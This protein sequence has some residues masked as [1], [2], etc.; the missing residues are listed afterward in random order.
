M[1]T[2]IGASG[3]EENYDRVFFQFVYADVL[4]F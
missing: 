3:E 1:Y 2:G 4:F